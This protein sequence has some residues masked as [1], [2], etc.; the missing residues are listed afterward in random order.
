MGE[1]SPFTVKDAL[2]QSLRAAKAGKSGTKKQQLCSMLSP[3]SRHPCP[4]EG[5]LN[6]S[7]SIPANA[8]W[9]W[10]GR[11]QQTAP[12]LQSCPQAGD[13]DSFCLWL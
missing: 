4:T 3:C 11:Q 2:Y 1:E 13:P 9:E 5:L 7:Y 12:V 6:P 8:S 10:Q